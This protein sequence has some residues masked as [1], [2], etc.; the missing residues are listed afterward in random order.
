MAE[1]LLS[2]S[3]S[4]G[5]RVLLR[6]IKLL[7]AVLLVFIAG[8]FLY[9]VLHLLTD[10]AFVQTFYWINLTNVILAAGYW[11]NRRGYYR[12]G[13]SLAVVVL[14]ISILI[15]TLLT[16]GNGR[17][18]YVMIMPVL[19]GSMLLSL[20]GTLLLAASDLAGLVS[21]AAFSPRLTLVE[22]APALGFFTTMSILL[23]VFVQHRDRLESERQTELIDNETQYRSLVENLNKIIYKMDREGHFTYLSPG[24]ELITGYRAEDLLGLHFSPFI[25]PE[26]LAAVEANFKKALSG[27]AEPIEF[28]ILGKNKK[29][30]HLRNFAQ[31]LEENHRPLGV[32]GVFSDI[33]AQKTLHDQLHQ[34]QKM[35]SVGRLA[36]GVAHD[37]N[38]I[39]TVI[40]GYCE[41]LAE[42]EKS[43]PGP[44]AMVKSIKSAAERAASLTRQ[45]LVFS[46]KQIF[47]PTRLNINGL[48]KNL[49]K[50]LHRLIGEHI[51]LKTHLA[52]EIH[53]I[54]TDAAQL[55]QVLMNLAVNARD[56][57][58]RGGTLL[59]ET[60][61]TYLDES[62]RRKYSEVIPGH[63][64]MLAISDTGC[65]M[66]EKTRENIFEPFFTTKEAGKGTG[67]GLSTVYGIVKQSGGHI[68]FYSE[69]D[70]GTTFKIYFPADNREMAEDKTKK[71]ESP[72]L[73]SLE[74]HES[75]LVVEDQEDLREMIVESLRLYGYHVQAAQ[76]GT[77]ALELCQ[78]HSPAPAN[79]P[80]A[81]LITDV[82]MPQM[83][84]KEL[85]DKIVLQYPGIKILYISGYTEQAIVE[86]NIL[87]EGLSF[88]PKPF[89]PSSLAEKVR[90]VLDC[91]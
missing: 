18:F 40:I 22:A 84:G 44:L 8:S 91:K 32:I 86:H 12:W 62:Y 74:G 53:D 52:E 60:T 4:I 10:A 34:A 1:R 85:A 46:R 65:G 51:T 67:L 26:D 49:E 55:E 30:L 36:G 68:C 25:F 16:T 82:V 72:D 78:R 47:Q 19:L 11:L 20:R 70:T 76:D 56:A 80:F 45:L 41:M 13:A 73:R 87:L 35:E 54:K 2:P 6:K 59:I 50:M 38:N 29:V 17:Y 33:T 69:V 79:Q 23:L 39:L 71:M 5:D 66:D 21:A 83:N 48:I 63:Y 43:N 15:S 64:V 14:S 77:E 57:M 58:P 37:F 7:A 88:L 3:V 31:L 42:D 81:M 28:R 75:L 24:L 61:N 27:L 89:S 9:S 90:Y